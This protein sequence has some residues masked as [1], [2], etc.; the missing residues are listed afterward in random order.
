MYPSFMGRTVA[1]RSARVSHD[2]AR[3]AS[4]STASRRPPGATTLLIVRHG[5]SAAAAPGPAVPDC[6]TATATRELDPVGVRQ[7][8]L[9]A[10][11]LQHE[12][13]DAIYVTTLRR[14]HQT[15]APLAARL[16]ITPVV[17]PDLREVFLGE[18]EGGSVPRA[19]GRPAIRSSSEIFDRAALGR[20]P[21]RRAATRRSTSGCGRRSS[22]SWRRTPTSG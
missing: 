4:A 1:P 11:R 9:L 5:E 10:D 20:D 15:A 21:R 12:T 6:A 17:E 16:G 13:I 8:E 2:T 18:W 19:S 14:T 3:G 22:G 7:A